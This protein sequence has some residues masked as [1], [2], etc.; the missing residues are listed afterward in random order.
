G[1][2]FNSLNDTDCKINI[3]IGSKKFMEGWNSWRVST[4]GLMNIGKK[5]GSQII[6][7]FGRGVRL[8]G[9]G[10]N[11]KRSRHVLGV[12]A[13]EHIEIIETLNIFGIHADYMQQFKEYLE[14]EGLPQNEEMLEYVLPVVKNLNGKKLKTLKLKEEADFKKKGP[15]PTLELPR[16]YDGFLKSP[17]VV[18]WYP[19]I[20]AQISGSALTKVTAEK[21]KGTLSP[22]HVAFMNID[23]IYFELQDHKNGKSWHNLNLSRDKIDELLSTPDW[24]TLYIP[25]EELRLTSFNRV[26]RWQEI[27]TALLKKY[28]EK[29]YVYRKK[30]YEAPYLE[31]KDLS[32]DDPNFIKEYRFLIQESIDG[33]VDT[34]DKIKDSINRKEY[35]DIEFSTF[36]KSISFGSHLYQPLI[37]C[38]ND[39]IQVKPV[40]LNEGERDF[41]T[42]LRKY[43]N[44]HTEF[45]QK[46][47][48]Y[49]LRNQSRGRGLGFFEAGNFYPDFILW[50]L[51]DDRQYIN[52]VDP[53]GL[54]N[55]E[56]RDDPKIIFY[57]RIKELE[58]NLADP[59]V[60]MNSFILSNTKYHQI[61]FWE[62]SKD[63][64]EKRNVLFQ[65][66]D[67]DAYIHK[68]MSKIC[69]MLC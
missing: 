47:E 29:Y 58:K 39:M 1:S 9:H 55:L 61:K 56:G 46:K 50:L 10:F 6:Q 43:H 42:D 60:K 21:E 23:D 37:Y 64:L 44:N 14:E 16:D 33:I 65:N 5:E 66:D 41:V 24:Y 8:K 3:L 12:K 69:S 68:M 31:Y 35:K 67:K 53:K 63:D 54:R 15:K 22:K 57:K 11:L 49:L 34:L 36:F 19:K 48:M 17:V 13:P 32:E 27:A 45:F 52:F 40:S 25:E 62:I 51:V 38:K 2:L 59:L 28:C 20:E 18:D 26:A 7:L 30:E 4:M